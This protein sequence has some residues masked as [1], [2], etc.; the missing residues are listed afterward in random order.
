MKNEEELFI[1]K[2]KHKALKI[3]LAILLIAGLITGAYFL[4]QYKFSN[5]KTIV[6]NI[7]TKANDKIKES[8]SQKEDNNNYKI[9]GLIKL[10]TNIKDETLEL[11]K[12]IDLQFSSEI[13][14]KESFGNI[15]INTKYKSDKLLDFN[16]Y[17]EK[18]LIYLLLKD[19]Y[20]KYIKFDTKSSEEN[21]PSNVS[22]ITLNTEDGKIIVNALM[23]SLN[24]EIDTLDFKKTDTNITIANKKIDVINNYIELKD[25]EV[26]NF[27]KG[28][29]NN[30]KNNQEFMKVLDKLTN[31]SAK[32][33]IQELEKGLEEEVFR[34]IYK[35]NFYTD[36]GI[37]HK[38]LISVRQ[39]I[40]VD[41]VTM[42][43]NV[44]KISDDEILISIA[45]NELTYSLKIKKNNS[46]INI[47]LNINVDGEYIE[48]E[49]NL[50][51]EKI[52]EVLKPDLS[53]SKDVNELTEEEN[54]EIVN[55]LAENKT[56]VKL[57][58]KINTLGQKGV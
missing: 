35:I 47:N 46:A 6:T 5:P 25:K 26:N 43:F 28:I 50:N 37:F 15:E 9:D 19:V 57:I 51:Y 58:E 32:E 24:K 27:I 49:V 17:Y 33:Y 36:K 11:L 52:K 3:I 30:L 40:V 53:N 4:Y 20:D 21:L 16:V 45:T 2:T 8:F 29:V 55:K 41:E 12:D 34:G 54:N 38:N 44:D 14:L 18:N 7:I 56:L 31:N 22:P 23:N 13:N 48:L 39:T 42:N 10:N 1:P